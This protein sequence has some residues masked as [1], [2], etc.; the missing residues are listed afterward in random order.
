[1]GF[2]IDSNGKIERIIDPVLE[3]EIDNYYQYSSDSE[4]NEL[5]KSAIKKFKDK[6]PETRKESLEKLWDAWE[7]LKTIYLE[8]DKKK[9]KENIFEENKKYSW[10][11]FV[12][13]IQ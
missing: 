10:D 11:S 5:I 4:L 8:L 1:M 13:L 2:Q 6:N 9:L 7:R 12:E 3:Y